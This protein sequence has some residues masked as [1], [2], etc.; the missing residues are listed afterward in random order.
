MRAK[1]FWNLESAAFAAI[2][3][4]RVAGSYRGSG[5]RVQQ[6]L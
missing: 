1:V 4:A 6:F 3:I 5:K 2:S